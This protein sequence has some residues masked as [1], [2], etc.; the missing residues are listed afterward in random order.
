[1]KCTWERAKDRQCLERRGGIFTA[2]VLPVSGGSTDGNDT[3]TTS[4][5]YL[6]AFSSLLSFSSWNMR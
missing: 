2:E 4:L 6:I 1:M 3:I 5:P